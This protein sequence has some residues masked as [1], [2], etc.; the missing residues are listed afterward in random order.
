MS[1]LSSEAIAKRSANLPINTGQ[2]NPLGKW[3]FHKYFQLKESEYKQLDSE[4]VDKDLL[5]KAKARLA[6][7]L[8]RGNRKEIIDISKHILNRI[9]PNANKP[10]IPDIDL[11]LINYGQINQVKEP[12]K[13]V[14]M[15]DV[16]DVKNETSDNI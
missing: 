14:D 9:D 8:D 12:V 10:I 2:I 5:L 16:I 1:K 15:I 13:P 6:V 11:I 4:S 7:F 3:I